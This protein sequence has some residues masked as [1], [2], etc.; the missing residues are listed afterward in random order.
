MN[1]K[2]EK[3]EQPKDTIIKIDGQEY[4]FN[5]NLY[6]QYA[7]VNKIK[8]QDLNNQEFVLKVSASSVEEFL[9]YISEE[10][11][12]FAPTNVYEIQYISMVLCC[13]T[14]TANIDKHIRN[15][16]S[17]EIYL[18]GYISFLNRDI[19]D[20]EIIL[21]KER[22]IKENI[23]TYYVLDQFINIP[24]QK[25]FILFNDNPKITGKEVIYVIRKMF[26]SGKDLYDF[27]QLFRCI[28]PE[29]LNDN[30]DIEF[31][32]TKIK[33]H[34]DIVEFCQNPI[35]PF[36]RRKRMKKIIRDKYNEIFCSEA[37]A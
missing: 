11:Y 2:R 16:K 20:P 34:N 17:P 8:Q 33:E 15:N 37:L 19:E 35:L 23:E 12:Y 10:E 36:L 5:Y 27:I 24:V 25:M 6:A 18:S 22:T 14:L 26:D 9:H 1:I 21:E 28:K 31:F 13:T 4:S 3:P 7:G 29:T 30:E 32:I